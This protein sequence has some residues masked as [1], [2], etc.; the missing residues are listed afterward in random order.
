MKIRQIFITALLLI[1]CFIARGYLV[2]PPVA[3]D[4]LANKADLIFQ[5]TTVSNTTITDPS[6]QSILG[7]VVQET[8]FRPAFAI[9]GKLGASNAKFR[10]YAP[11]PKPVGMMYEPQSY[12]FEIGKS[13]LVF[14]KQLPGYAADICQQIWMSHTGMMDEGVLLCFRPFPFERRSMKDLFWRDLTELLKS[15][16]SKEVVYAITHLNEF[17]ASSGGPWGSFGSISEFQR[18][19]VL[20]AIHGLVTHPDPT[21]AQAALAVVG[22]HNPYMTRE[23]AQYW[24]ATIGSADTPGFTKMDPKMVNEGGLIYWREIAAIVDGKADEA[25]RALSV[26]ALGLVREPALQDSVTRWLSDPS[27]SV[28]S[29]AVLLLADY[30]ALATHDR[31]VALSSDADTETRISASYAIGFAQLADNADVLTKLL[32]DADAKVRQAAAMSLLSFSPKDERIAKIFHDNLTNKEFAVLFLV[33]LC[34]ANPAANLDL[35]IQE[36]IKKTDPENWPGGQIPA[37]TTSHLLYKYLKAQPA[38]DLQSGKYDRALDALEIWQPN[39]SIDPQFVY[40][41]EIKDGLTGRAKKFR[42][43]ANKASPYDL[44]IY[45]QRVDQNPNSYLID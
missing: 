38:A 4:D 33:A 18:L 2:G 31:F 6:F 25:T 26:T 19:D 37:Y 7:F 21:V 45:F 23:R 30:P 12:A 20:A 35:L 42:T 43:A 40:A 34:Q 41:L 24:L 32:S 27:A 16:D 8:E 14:A 22:S 28:R 29:S 5:G 15:T 1:P 17:S 11:D 44:E 3:L 13:Y 36:T 10:H 9:K 39:Y